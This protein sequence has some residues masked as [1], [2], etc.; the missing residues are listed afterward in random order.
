MTSF[1]WTQVIWNVMLCQQT[2]ASVSKEYGAFIIEG[3]EESLTLEYG[4]T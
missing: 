4:D 1:I 3:Q 2:G